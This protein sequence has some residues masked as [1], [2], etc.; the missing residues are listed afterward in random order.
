MRVGG[1]IKA[2]VRIVYVPPAYPELARAAGINAV[3]V[4]ECTIDP[5]GNV[6]GVRVVT[7]HP[8]FD[9]AAVAAV[10]QWRYTPSRLNGVPVP[11]LMT[12]TIR[13]VPKR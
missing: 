4:L 1:D 6:V 9:A 12:V 11:V 7:G 5:T 2:P 3:V 10:R 13:F 8:L